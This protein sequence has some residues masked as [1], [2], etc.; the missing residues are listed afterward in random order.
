MT[1]S[2]HKGWLMN[3]LTWEEVDN[4]RAEHDNENAARCKPVVDMYR[5]AVESKFGA[6]KQSI[7]DAYRRGAKYSESCE[8]RSACTI[9]K[10]RLATELEVSCKDVL[11]SDLHVGVIIVDRTGDYDEKRQ[12]YMSISVAEAVFPNGFEQ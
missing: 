4:A 9:S 11:A 10:S 5:T 12:L 1:F 8:A 3:R 2:I 6:C 7:L